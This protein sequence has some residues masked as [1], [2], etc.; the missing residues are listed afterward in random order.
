[1][2][3][4]SHQGADVQAKEVSFLGPIRVTAATA[5][6]R[7]LALKW[8]TNMSLWMV[9]NQHLHTSYLAVKSLKA[10]DIWNKRFLLAPAF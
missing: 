2:L 7:A 9:L 6:P 4:W 3:A 5:Q 8:D 1:M 10:G